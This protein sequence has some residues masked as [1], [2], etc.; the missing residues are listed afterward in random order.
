MATQQQRGLAKQE[1]ATTDLAPL[2]YAVLSIDVQEMGQVLAENVGEEGIS[3]F[4]LDR[5]KVP[6]SAATI[7]MVPTLEGEEPQRTI[8]GILIFQKTARTFWERRFEDSGG[9]TAP[10][11]SSDDGVIGI[12]TPKY[13]DIEHPML[14]SAG[15]MRY[16]T[17][18]QEL[19][20]GRFDCKSCPLATFG[21]G[22][23]GRQQACKQTRMLF[24]V[25]EDS[26]LP[27]LISAPPS[28]LGSMKKYMTRLSS[29]GVPYYG[30]VT[31][32]SLRK[33]KNAD[34]IEYAEIVPSMTRRLERDD[35]LKM[36]ELSI[37]MAPI[38]SRVKPDVETDRPPVV[39]DEESAQADAEREA[40]LGQMR[41]PAEA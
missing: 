41:N 3:A 31:G 9:G 37:Y 5:V 20:V 23:N 26:L 14:R 21:S 12:G 18:G 22:F 8:E 34:G 33:E 13:G 30:V 11:C 29:A 2:E 4:D 36:R 1:P 15:Q 25:R 28:S 32:L 7:W 19:F 16:T 27:I 24:L 10:D 38:L 17:E 40:F 6:G 39:Q 35:M